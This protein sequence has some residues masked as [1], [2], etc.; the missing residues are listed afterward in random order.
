MILLKRFLRF[1][2][3]LNYRHYI[4]VAI[5]LA[6]VCL[7]VFIFPNTLLR[8]FES[9]RDVGTSIGYSFSEFFL[10]INNVYPTV[11]D[12]PTWKF[13]PSRFTQLNVIP[14]TWDEFVVLVQRYVSSLINKRTFLNYILLWVKIISFVYIIVVCSFFLF[15]PFKYFLKRF[16]KKENNDYDK[17]SFFVV[18]LKK[19][20]GKLYVPVKRWIKQFIDFTLDN[21]EYLIL[22]A[23][24]FGLY[25]NVFTIALELL[26]YLIYFVTS[27]DLANIYT[28]F[29]KL[30][31]DLTNIVRFIP[32][33]LWIIAVIGLLESWARKIGHNRLER[34]ECRNSAFL[35]ERGVVTVVY[36]PM[37]AGKTMLIT[38][39]ALTEEVRLRDMAFEIIIECDFK[40]PN[41]TWATLENE[42][43]QAIEAH[44]VYSLSTVRK[45]VIKK[46][47]IWHKVQTVAN[48]F[49]YDYIVYGLEYN[50]GL[51]ISNVWEIILDYCKAYFVYTVQSSLILSNYSIRVDNLMEDVGNFPLWNTDFFKRDSRLMDSYSRH[52]HIIDYDMLRL[53]KRVVK[54]NPNRYAFGFGVYVISE[55]DKERKNDKELRDN[56]VLASDKNAN[57]RNDLFN[58]LLKM[59][60][61]ACVISN[62]VFV[63]VLADLQ[64]PESLGA[65]ARELGEIQYIDNRG[66]MSPV[67]PFFAPFYL[68]NYLF[69]LTFGKFVKFYY[70][71]RF[72]RGDKTT[73][74][75]TGKN[76][77][78]W[79]KG[80]IDRTNNLYNSSTVKL[81]IESGRMDGDSVLS[82]YFLQ[83]KKTFS[84]RFSTD[85]LSGVFSQYA[86]LNTIG[87]DDLPEYASILAT[88][89]E[90]QKQNSFFQIEIRSYNK[91]EK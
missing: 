60:R 52:S 33:F 24:F 63:K 38:D 25:F 50:D 67:L 5:T 78:S 16:I 71:Y 64:R 77:F 75:Y 81:K 37:G 31:I 4:L 7:G 82:K 87:V 21:K 76:F 39:M 54:D 13:A 20:H 32:G 14:F 40:F 34:R 43:K 65:D 80:I 27:F 83:S 58:A 55:I 45:W 90:L 74:V 53:G 42:L 85:C 89:F 1:L 36:G 8:F 57:Q 49:G 84:K 35:E 79:L 44:K 2:R 61:H 15:L 48:L 10:D 9:M 6:F 70:D 46:Y 86:E 59:S 19:L 26:A 41:M 51:K 29:Y 56:N 3:N 62:R 91:Q 18:F 47:K 68:L 72:Y 73:L 11:L 22:W 23:V 66:E 28:Q 17:E 69:N 88:E 30:F 12:M